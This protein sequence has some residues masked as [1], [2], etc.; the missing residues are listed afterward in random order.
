MTS[1]PTPVVVALLLVL[2]AVSNRQQLLESR[3]GQAFTLVLYLNAL[4]MTLVGIRWSWDIPE[5][6]SIAA[7]LSVIS[8]AILY[9]AFRSLGQRGPVL[10]LSRDW[11]H[12]L[13]AIAV[14]INTV[15]LPQWI[16]I[17]L[18]AA[19][20]LYTLLLA[21]LARG[22]PDSVQLVRLSWLKNTQQALWGATLLLVLSLI[23]DV[24]IILDFLLYDGVH[25]PTLVGSA[26]LFILILLGWASVQAGQGRS[27]DSEHATSLPAAPEI[28]PQ[29]ESSTA[30]A[31]KPAAH[32]VSATAQA[33]DAALLNTLN[34]L[35]IQERLY[36]D[37]D[38]NLQKLARKAGVPAR[39]ISRVINAHTGH[40]LSQWVN[41]ARIDAACAL[42]KAPEVSVTSAMLESGFLTKS[43]FHR[44]FRRIHGCSPGEWRLAQSEPTADTARRS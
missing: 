34:T 17:S 2:L 43:N 29:S 11:Y 7:T 25:A 32:S 23:I 4:S 35:L 14:V 44:E 28:N 30:R 36:A 37:T 12:A 21:R 39:S 16:D 13:P 22:M 27:D 18:I 33:D 5:V 42:L 6:L 1:I 41:R 24:A 31:D 3:T 20:L 26:S 8:S 10:S 19:K 9:L 40:N 38:L 15:L